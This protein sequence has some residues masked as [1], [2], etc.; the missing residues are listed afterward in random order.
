MIGGH[1]ART[2]VRDGARPVSEAVP[3]GLALAPGA[4]R[5]LDLVGGGRYTPHEIVREAGHLAPPPAP[6][7]APGTPS[8]TPPGSG[9]NLPCGPRGR[10]DH[11]GPPPF[12][13]GAPGGRTRAEH[14]RA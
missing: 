14:D 11:P 5:P 2:A 1:V 4:V 13:A 6:G 12:A 3:D 9:H 8:P 10:R 7:A